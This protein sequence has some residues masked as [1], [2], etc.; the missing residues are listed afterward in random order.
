MQTTPPYPAQCGWVLAGKGRSS[1]ALDKVFISMHN[2]IKAVCINDVS[3]N[4]SYSWKVF[5]FSSRCVLFRYPL[6]VLEIQKKRVKFAIKSMKLG[7][8]SIIEIRSFFT[9][10]W[11]KLVLSHCV[12]LCMVPSRENS[13]GSTFLLE[14]GAVKVVIELSET[15]EK[16]GSFAKERCLPIA[17]T[18]FSLLARRQINIRHI[19][20][21]LLK[22]TTKSGA[23]LRKKWKLLRSQEGAPKK[24]PEP[25]THSCFSHSA[26][27]DACEKIRK[28]LNL[29]L[30][31]TKNDLAFLEFLPGLSCIRSW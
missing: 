2:D 22:L 8:E 9:V 14:S 25:L 1:N 7:H 6:I 3:L 19:N 13:A 27:R 31:W 30:K 29:L 17:K 12:I 4:L 24:L 16:R 18:P 10:E 26:T 11:M 23:K 20:W 15:A 5:K 28:G 21:S